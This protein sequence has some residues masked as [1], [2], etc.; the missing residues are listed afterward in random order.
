[1]AKVMFYFL[2][3]I[4]VIVLAALLGAVFWAKTDTLTSGGLALLDGL[5]GWSLR[6]MVT[7]L[8]PS[9]NQTLFKQITR[10]YLASGDSGKAQ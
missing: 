6:Y 7:H 4:F 1:M 10:R 5:I 9:D 2:L 8:F 3:V